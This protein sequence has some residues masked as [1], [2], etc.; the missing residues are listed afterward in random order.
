M[1]KIISIITVCAACFLTLT[2]CSREPKEFEGLKFVKWGAGN[3]AEY[4]KLD[5]LENASVAVVVGT[6]VEDA[7]QKV[8]YQYNAAFSK[9]I[10]SWVNSYNT[11]EVSRVLKGDVEVGDNLK[12]TQL[13]AVVDGQLITMSDLTPMVK[14]DTW[15][16]FL[17]CE[18]GS[19]IYWVTGDSDGRY[20]V[21][22]NTNKTLAITQYSNL[23]VYKKQNFKSGIYSEI[24]E[25]Y[26]I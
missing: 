26:D 11:I 17:D 1:K 5:D 10:V 12:L 8:Q 22:S 25:K 21:S 14:G 6:F 15:I 23:G 13:Y 4:Y 18:E 19:D 7:E 2:A 3:R 20:P 16:F 9:E 24:L